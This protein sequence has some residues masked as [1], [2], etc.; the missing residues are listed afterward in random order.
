MKISKTIEQMDAQFAAKANMTLKQF[1]SLTL[2]KQAQVRRKIT[3][4]RLKK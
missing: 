2:L 4:K 1:K 3:N